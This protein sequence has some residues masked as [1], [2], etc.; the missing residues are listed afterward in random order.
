MPHIS[1]LPLL[2]IITSLNLGVP[3]VN[4]KTNPNKP[5]DSEWA[6]QTDIYVGTNAS[7]LERYAAAE[8]QRYLYQLSGTLPVIR[9]GQPDGLRNTFVIG[10]HVTIP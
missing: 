9:S 5:A 6:K 4:A 10:C 2:L 7:E 3:L 8:L 1:W